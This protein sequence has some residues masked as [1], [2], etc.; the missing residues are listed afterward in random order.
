MI[1]FL[2]LFSMDKKRGLYLS[3]RGVNLKKIIPILYLFLL[4][5]FLFSITPIVYA[6][7]LNTIFNEGIESITGKSAVNVSISISLPPNISFVSLDAQS[8]T[9]LDGG[10]RDIHV[11]FLVDDPEGLGDLDNTSAKFNISYYYNTTDVYSNENTS[12]TS[13]TASDV[14]NYSCTVQMQYWWDNSDKWTYSAEIN[15]TDGN[16]VQNSSATSN[17]WTYAAF[18]GFNLSSATLDWITLI[19]SKTNQ[20]SNTTM[21][22]ENTGNQATL[23][24]STTMMDL[25]GPVGTYI[26]AGNFSVFNSTTNDL[27]CDSTNQTE[28]IIYGAQPVVGVNDSAVDI[29]LDALARGPGTNP[30]SLYYCLFEVPAIAALESGAYN[31]TDENSWDIT[32]ST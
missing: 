25:G 8:H 4:I 31:A 9:P 5:I 11:S 10:V 21:T 27:E 1:L 14:I 23:N 7:F 28:P 12:C 16:Y 30:E 24:I 15:D 2:F 13:A 18:T 3:Q 26:P 22:A 20:T 6:G 32:A 17:N 19:P 29:L